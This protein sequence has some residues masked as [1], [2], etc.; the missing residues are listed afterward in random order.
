MNNGL[1]NIIIFSGGAVTGAAAMYF[2][3]KNI[4]TKK[5][6][7]TI[8]K[9][10]DLLDNFVDYQEQQDEYI[11][12][13]LDTEHA[14]AIA[15]R[16]ELNKPDVSAYAK[17]LKDAGYKK[18]SEER[19]PELV[20]YT[21]FAR[22]EE[23]SSVKEKKEESD[24]NE[25]EEEIKPIRVIT[26]EYFDE[27]SQDDFDFIN[28]TYFSDHILTDEN[29]EKMDDE[30]IDKTITLETLRWI[31]THKEEDSIYVVNE[32]LKT[33]YEIVRDLR[34]YEDVAKERGGW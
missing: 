11:V 22:K 9:Y 13:E 34:T 20:D 17:S 28:F 2:V 7:E 31:D 26:E 3:A 8:Y 23:K 25:K 5:L 14:K 27:L 32:V 19:K 10:E 6:N 33:A 24:V 18:D 30:E 4:F 12:E 16:K 15:E 21:T 1:K 29:D